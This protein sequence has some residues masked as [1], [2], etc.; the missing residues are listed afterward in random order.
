MLKI[1][2]ERTQ[3]RVVADQIG[4]PT[5][6]ALVAM[7]TSRILGQVRESPTAM[8]RERGGT[9]HVPCGGETSWHG[10]AEE[11]FRLARA[12][13]LPLRVERVVPIATADY[14]TP[15]RRPLN[16]RLDGRVAAARFGLCLPDWRAAL[17]AEFPAIVAEIRST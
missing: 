8:L 9:I 15:A 12:A 14:P 2:G 4:A 5:P 10:F 11:I 17:A 1:G 7:A 3:L 13:G 6:A 16:S